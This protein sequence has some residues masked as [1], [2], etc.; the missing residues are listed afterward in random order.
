MNSAEII[1]IGSELLTPTK[2][3]TNSLWLTEKLNDTGIEVMLKDNSGNVF[4]VVQ[5]TR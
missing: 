3:D 2:T 5:R 4:S 1:A